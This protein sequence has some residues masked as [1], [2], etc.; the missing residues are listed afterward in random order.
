MLSKLDELKLIARCVAVDDRD[1]FGRLVEE[2]QDGLRRFLMNLTMGDASLSDDLSQDTFLKAYL[3]IRSFRGLS[4]FKT[5][6]Y[7][8]AYNE[9]CS[10]SRRRKEEREQDSYHQQDEGT[11]TAAVSDARMDIET[12]LKL[13]NETER[14][15]ALLFYL[16]DQ[17]IKKIADIT[18]MPQGTIK[19]YLA[20]ARVKMAETLKH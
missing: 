13:L 11:S 20:R 9:Y 4:R 5:W 1:A 6:L 14:T 2:Y 19:S 12:C 7:R 8:I 17:P 3:S 16:E 10:Y 18:G 15:V